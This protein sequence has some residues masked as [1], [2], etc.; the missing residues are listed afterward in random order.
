MVSDV[1]LDPDDK[2]LRYASPSR[3]CNGRALPSAF[4]LRPH[5]AGLSVNSLGMCGTS[6]DERA[7]Q[8][9]IAT[10]SE[11]RK[12]SRNGLFFHLPVRSVTETLSQ[13]VS[14]VNVVADPVEYE[15]R[16]TGDVKVDCSHALIKWI[17][18]NEL[19]ARELL[20]DCVSGSTP[21]E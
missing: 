10:M 1:C 5:E 2:V 11:K 3:C 16:D 6:C 19:I 7:I 21:V 12:L 17:E 9:I 18:G 8:Q 14:G 15:C 13:Q 4:D 20:V